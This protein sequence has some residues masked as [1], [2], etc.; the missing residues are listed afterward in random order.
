MLSGGAVPATDII[1][2]CDLEGSSAKTA[3]RAMRRI[4]AISRSQDGITVWEM[5]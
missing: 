1:E 4:G 5:P 2:A 3:R